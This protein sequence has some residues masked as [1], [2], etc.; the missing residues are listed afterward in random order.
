MKGPNVETTPD[1]NQKKVM[2]TSQ[3]MTPHNS[4]QFAYF[5]FCFVRT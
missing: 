4:W 2:L 3:T 1:V 5:C